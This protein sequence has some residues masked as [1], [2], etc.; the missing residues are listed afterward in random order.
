MTIKN[1]F[2]LIMRLEITFLVYEIHVG[3][4]SDGSEFRTQD[5]AFYFESQRKDDTHAG[6]DDADSHTE[7]RGKAVS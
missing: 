7:T 1:Y 5:A 4:G 2:L 6:S 3:C